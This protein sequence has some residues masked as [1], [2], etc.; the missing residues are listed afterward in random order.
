MLEHISPLSFMCFIL[1]L[2]SLNLQQKLNLILY[3]QN[4]LSGHFIRIVLFLD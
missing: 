2:L 4:I 1:L 3:F